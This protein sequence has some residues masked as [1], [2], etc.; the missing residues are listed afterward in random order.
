MKHY[1]VTIANLLED[2]SREVVVDGND[3]YLAHK[4]AIMREC[5]LSE[6]VV[7]IIDPSDIEVFNLKLGFSKK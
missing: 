7:R 4:H 3:V 5:D 6:E 2:T 1:T